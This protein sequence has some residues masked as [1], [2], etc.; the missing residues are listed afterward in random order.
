MSFQYREP[1]KVV[2]DI[3]IAQLGLSQSQVMFSNEKWNIPTVGPLVIV[4]YLGPSKTIN[5]TDTWVDDGAGGLKEV[6]TVTSFD[7]IEIQILGY[8]TPSIRAFRTLIPMA[9]N[10]LFAQAQAELWNMSIALNPGPMQD[11][12]YVEGTEMI[13]RY[14]TT[15]QATSINENTQPVPDIYTDFSKAIPPK[16]VV[17]A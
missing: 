12:S 3:L 13:T 5:S 14:T 16:L 4:S 15:I 17:N 6:Q 9:F 8:K 7:T 1:G 11:T 10:S 2:K